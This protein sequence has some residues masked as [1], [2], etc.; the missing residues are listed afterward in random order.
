MLIRLYL[1]DRPEPFRELTEPSEHFELDTTSL[2]DGRHVLHLVTIEDGKVTGRRDVEF[3]VRN[4]PGIALAGLRE[5][6]VVRGSVALVGNASGGSAGIDLRRVETRRGLPLWVGILALA[7]VLAATM[8]AA[9][10]PFDFR[11]YQSQADAI[12]TSDEMSAL[13]ESGGAEEPAPPPEPFPV[14]LNPG[15]YMPVLDFDP[16]SADAVRGSVIYQTRCTGCHGGDAE[17]RVLPK[18]TLGQAGI[19]PRLAGQPAAYLYRQLVSFA[20]GTRDSTEMKPMALSLTPQQRG[21]VAVYLAGLRT[22]YPP[23]QPLEEDLRK[24]G[25]DIA[26]N[27]RPER[28]INR[29]DGCHGENGAG[30]APHFPALIA[31]N[32]TYILA[33]LEAWRDGRRRNALLQLMLPVAHGLEGEEVWAVGAYYETVR[34]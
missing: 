15:D 18:A 33:Q 19:Y 34:P 1:D 16:A 27:G 24:L 32:R 4:G 14:A 21:D 6:D 9:F 13:S 26:L 2:T 23:A 20:E 11:N 12:A 17:G 5:G 10:D 31:Q 3:E 30:V 7:V 28:G 8:L 25:S 29:C 22:P